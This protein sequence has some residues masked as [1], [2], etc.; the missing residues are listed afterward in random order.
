M[1][2]SILPLAILTC[3]SAVTNAQI[4]SAGGPPAP[5][6][7]QRAADAFARHDW[8]AAR[9]AYL[10]IATQYPEHALSRFRV[11]VAELEL[12]KFQDA[13]RDLREGERLG[14]PEGQSAYR[15]AELFAARH[16]SDSAFAQLQRAA[17]NGLTVPSSSL[18]ADQHLEPLKV[19]PAWKVTLEAFEAVVFPCRHDPRFR[20]FDFW[21]GDWDVRPTG[22]PPVGPP[23]RNTVTLD[24][25][26]CVVTEH[27]SSPSG[28]VGQS[29]NV[30]DRS[31]G[32]WRQTWVDNIGEQ[33]DYRGR[34]V[35][36]NMVFDGDTPAPNGQQGRIPTRL[37][38]FNLGPDTVRQFSQSSTDSGRTWQINYDLTYVR[39]RK[40]P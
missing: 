32:V 6:D 37:T 18:E 14:I 9:A 7:L 22:Q 40:T 26:D 28:S 5:V 30:F 33:H 24:D 36:G 39:R 21:V 3:T 31:Y 13:E 8:T 11:G 20:Q 29:F 25:N 17:R 38:F 27:W 15:L 16:N 12:G 1:R 23:A 10:A 4:S 35:D 2:K 19:Y 34:L